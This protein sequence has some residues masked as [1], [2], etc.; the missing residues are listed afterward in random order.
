M[1]DRFEPV[2][3]RIE[4]IVP[5][6]QETYNRH[7]FLPPWDPHTLRATFDRLNSLG[8]RQIYGR[9]DGGRW[10]ACFGLWDYSPVM[11]MAFRDHH[12]EVSVR[13]F[14]LYPLGWRDSDALREVILAAQSMITQE[15]GILL[16]PYDPQE[17][18]G[19]FVPR[20]A[21]QMGMTLYVRNFS[22]ERIDKREP[23]FVDPRDL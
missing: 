17:A 8:W 5:L 2:S 3:N 16:L 6:L 7:H 10:V 4:E 23:I 13:P 12:R 11:R 20:Q 19:P 15:E 22:E 21:I 14:F 18:I 9:K 1:A